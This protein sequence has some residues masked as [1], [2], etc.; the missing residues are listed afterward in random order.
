MAVAGCGGGGGGGG[1]V[2]SNPGTP[3]D[4]CIVAVTGTAGSG[5]TALSHDVTFTLNVLLQAGE[6]EDMHVLGAG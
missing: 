4:T 3:G 2:T 6:G 5:R 1:A